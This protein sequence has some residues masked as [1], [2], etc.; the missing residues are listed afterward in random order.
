MAERGEHRPRG[1]IAPFTADVAQGKS[2]AAGAYCQR[3]AQHREAIAIQSDVG[4]QFRYAFPFDVN[5]N[6]NYNTNYCVFFEGVCVGPSLLWEPSQNA[7]M[8]TLPTLVE[9]LINHCQ[10]L[11]GSRVVT[12]L[13]EV[14]HDSGAEESDSLHCKFS[15]N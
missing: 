2:H 8:R 4:R 11:F 7:P 5:D 10:N 3:T 13:G 14:A 15:L 9:M 6:F 12:L 1:T